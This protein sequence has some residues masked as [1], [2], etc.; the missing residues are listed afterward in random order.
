MVAKN[1]QTS[2]PGAAPLAVGALEDEVG[3]PA[4]VALDHHQDHSHAIREPGDLRGQVFDAEVLAVP[5]QERG[6]AGVVL[7]PRAAVGGRVDHEPV[8]GFE[9]LTLLGE[10][11]TEVLGVRAAANV[12]DG[13]GPVRLP[14]GLGLAEDAGEQ[15]VHARQRVVGLAVLEVAGGVV[16]VA[17]E[18]RFG[19]AFGVE[20]AQQRAEK[21]DVLLER[22]L[23][24]GRLVTAS[25]DE[26]VIVGA[27]CR[28]DGDREQGRRPR[29]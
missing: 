6:V 26:E 11:A 28:R 17:E 5:E 2:G 9:P 16:P 15:Q 29:S 13:V 18:D 25:D 22:D 8:A 23:I 10:P 12:G 19:D 24:A 20:L 27:C 7:G 4:G 1:P 14:E 3:E 21:Q